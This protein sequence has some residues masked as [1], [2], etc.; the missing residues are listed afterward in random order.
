MSSRSQQALINAKL[1]LPA[2]NP[3]VIARSRL[4]ERVHAGLQQALTVITAPAGFGKTTMVAEALRERARRR[5]VAWLSLDDED[6]HLIRFL[7]H[8]VATLQSI[9]PDVGRAPIFLI[10]R[11]QLP[12]SSDLITALISEIAESPR[13]IVLVLDGYQAVASPEINAALNF[14]VDHLPEQ[15]RVVLVSREVPDLPLARW[16]LQHR[17]SEI[18]L[19]DLRFSLEE[20]ALFLEQVIGLSLPP[21]LLRALPSGSLPSAANIGTCPIIWRKRYSAASPPKSRIFC[22]APRAWTAFARRCATP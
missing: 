12:A 18:G 6:S 22:A 13:Q 5:E 21:D 20:S 7:Y 1:S 2:A 3:R 10:G 8:L 11:L 19:E 16:R 15:L 9:A 17:L 4:S 14:L